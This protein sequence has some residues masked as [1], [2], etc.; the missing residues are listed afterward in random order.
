MV[1]LCGVVVGYL[2]RHPFAIMVCTLGPPRTGSSSRSTMNL[3]QVEPVALEVPIYEVK[4]WV[5]PSC[6]AAWP[7]MYPYP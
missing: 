2:L 6:L 4:T 1:H 7:R 5:Y 3:T